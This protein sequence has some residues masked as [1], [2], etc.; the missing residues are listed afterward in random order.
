MIE[1]P[2]EGAGTLL[3]GTLEHINGR[4]LLHDH[5]VFHK[6]DAVGHVAGKAH[7]MGDDQHGHPVVSQVAHDGQHLASQLGVQRGGGLV[8]IDDLR[9]R[10]KGAGNGHALLLSSPTR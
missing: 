10:C 8:E 6:R 3:T 4:A 2:Q 9:V 1:R 5:A 7:F